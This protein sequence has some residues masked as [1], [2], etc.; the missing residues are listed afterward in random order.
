[1][2]CAKLARL[3][4]RLSHCF[5]SYYYYYCKFDRRRCSVVSMLTSTVFRS[6]RCVHFRLLPA[7][8]KFYRRTKLSSIIDDSI[9]ICRPVLLLACVLLLLT[10]HQVFCR[11]I[12]EDDEE[13]N[14]SFSMTKISSS[15]AL[16]RKVY[17]NQWAVRLDGVT[18]DVDADRI[19]AKYGFINNGRI[20]H[21]YYS[22]T[23]PTLRKRSIR[24]ARHLRYELA[25]DP[26][27]S[28]ALLHLSVFHLPCCLVVGL[29]EV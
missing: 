6:V 26:Q 15:S 7:H 8:R 3:T 23:R 14:N 29:C 17:T 11:T 18:S 1:M 27:V 2:I 21:N 10:K 9:R 4:R 5:S 12:V 22:F 25:G 16:G 19:A 20:L 24:N 13:N 28:L